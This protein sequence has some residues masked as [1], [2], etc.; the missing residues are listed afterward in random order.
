MSM[1]D[2]VCSLL[3]GVDLNRF[4]LLPAFIIAFIIILC[5]GVLFRALMSIF[6]VFFTGR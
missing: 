6:N 1:Y 3:E 2:Y 5:I 4:S